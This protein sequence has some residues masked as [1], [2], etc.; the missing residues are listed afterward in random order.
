MSKIDIDGLEELAKGATPGP[1][2]VGW[3]RDWDLFDSV[4]GD[5]MG[6]VICE[7]DKCSDVIQASADMLYIAYMNPATALL[8]FE[9]MRRL[10][11]EN[12]KL[13]AQIEE[14]RK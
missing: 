9:E 12:K 13:R 2:S 11:A 5:N 10:Q 1:W 4:C 7:A 3:G 14:H 8:I 6:C